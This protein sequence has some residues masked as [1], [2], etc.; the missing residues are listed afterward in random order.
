[1]VVIGASAGGVEALGILL[2]ALPA[3]CPMPIAIVLH[4]P[5]DRASLL[6]SIFSARCAL[7][8]KEV[9]DKEPIR[10]GVVYFPAP[11]YH[12]LIEPDRTFALSQ[13]QPVNYSRPSI[14]VLFESAAMAYREHVLGIILTGA[15][16]DGAQGL[17]A[18]RAA[19]GCA[20]VQ[21]PEESVSAFMPRAAI[22]RAGAEQILTLKEMAQQLAVRETF[23]APEHKGRS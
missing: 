23:I 5:P 18:I 17:Q 14:D 6:A 22:E 19:G 3:H 9:E 7:S 16:A 1:M 8:V 2:S 13:D 11:D 4:I 20:W 10:S 21:L 15:S 12:M